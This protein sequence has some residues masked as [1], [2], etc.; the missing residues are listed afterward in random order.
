MASTGRLVASGVT[1]ISASILGVDPLHVGAALTAA[2]PHVGSWHVDVMDGSFAPAFGFGPAMVA[3]LVARHDRPVDVHLML[4]RPDVWAPRFAAMGVRAVAFQI[5]TD[6]DAPAVAAAI[7][8][9]G[10]E[11]FAALRPETPIERVG[12]LLD[13]VD[14]VLLLTAPAGGGPFVPAAL[15]KAFAVPPQLL[16][17]VDGRIDEGQFATVKAAAIT[18]VVIGQALF[19]STDIGSQANHLALALADAA[20]AAEGRR[21][22][23]GT[24]A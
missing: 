8:R 21:R 9:A 22:S 20:V 3:A 5:E 7:R 17:I 2:A 14:G 11:A 24:R 12:N 16:T 13:R 18:D 1:A 4:D 10:A 19:A 15:E 6:V 23:A